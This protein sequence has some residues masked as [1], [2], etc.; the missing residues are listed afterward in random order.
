MIHL[1]KDI[2]NILKDVSARSI[3]SPFGPQTEIFIAKTF[4]SYCLRTLYKYVIFGKNKNIF[5]DAV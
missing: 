2:L 3:E 4:L 1:P 5:K